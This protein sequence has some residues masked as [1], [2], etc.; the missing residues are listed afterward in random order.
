MAQKQRHRIFSGFRA[1]FI[2]AT[3]LKPA[4]G[5]YAHKYFRAPI[6]GPW[7]VQ[8]QTI[9]RCNASCIMCPYPS[10]EK[11]G[12]PNSMEDSLYKKILNELKKAGTRKI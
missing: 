6:A 9:D 1:R 4:V 5:A 10:F 7:A 12:P 8:V 11:H 2:Y 3:M